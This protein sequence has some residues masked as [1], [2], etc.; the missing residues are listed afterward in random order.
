MRCNW[1]AYKMTAQ[2]LDF[3]DESEHVGRWVAGTDFVEVGGGEGRLHGA[4]MLY[5]CTV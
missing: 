4:M 5:G 2:S 1:S 3:P